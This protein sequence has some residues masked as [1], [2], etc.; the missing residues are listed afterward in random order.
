[1]KKFISSLV[2][3]MVSFPIFAN[4][5]ITF[6]NKL[7]NKSPKLVGLKEFATINGFKYNGDCSGFIAF[8]F[9]AAGLN[10]LNLY[11]QGDSGVS[12][13]WDGLN[14]NNLL[15]DHKNLQ[16]GDIVFFDN[17]YDKNKNGL[18]DDEFSHIGV[19]E[20][21]DENQ[22]ITYLHYGSRGVARAKMNLSY[23]EIYSMNQSG[24]MVRYNDLIR[25]SSKK[26]VN[27]KYL[28]GALYR[29]AARIIVSK[30]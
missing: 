25:N 14:I 15:L 16:A 24:R 3:C 17:T 20:S 11:G 30:K 21:V 28:S 27:P 22:T 12:A 29:G 26:G 1:M 7:L 9:H 4:D 8:L 13:I 19:V 18:W 5:N 6:Y 2:L 10:L 23:P